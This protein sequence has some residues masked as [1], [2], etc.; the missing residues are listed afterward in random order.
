[1]AGSILDY[2][3]ESYIMGFLGKNAEY[4]VRKSTK[5]LSV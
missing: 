3:S 1:M 5:R 4:Q 2:T